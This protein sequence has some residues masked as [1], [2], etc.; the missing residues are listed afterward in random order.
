MQAS[1]SPLSACACR[2]ICNPNQCYSTQLLG[3]AG[4]TNQSQSCLQTS[5]C[6]IIQHKRNFPALTP[7]YQHP[8]CPNDDVASLESPVLGPKL[9]SCSSCGCASLTRMLL[10]TMR[11]N[12]ARAAAPTTPTTRV[13]HLLRA[14]QQDQPR[15]GVACRYTSVHERLNDDDNP[16]NTTPG[17]T[18]TQKAPTSPAVAG[19]PTPPY[20]DVIEAMAHLTPEAISGK[21]PVPPQHTTASGAHSRAVH[22]AG[23]CQGRGAAGRSQGLDGAQRCLVRYV[24]CPNVRAAA[25]PTVPQTPRPPLLSPHPAV[26]PQE[27]ADALFCSWAGCELMS[28]EQRARE[29]RRWRQAAAAHRAAVE[30]HPHPQSGVKW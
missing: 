28:P 11:V 14:P 12:G 10:K 25:M 26:D 5:A 21:A 23:I 30:W 29:A 27:V 18:S 19:P 16:S 20:T 15:R 1:V 3:R 9:H 6:N 4:T 13:S 8:R 17:N 22:A 2:G 7:R 24:P